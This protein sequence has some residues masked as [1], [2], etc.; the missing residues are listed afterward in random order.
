[1][2]RNTKLNLTLQV[3]QSQ[4]NLVG[5]MGNSVDRPGCCDLGNGLGAEGQPLRSEPEDQDADLLLM[6]LGARSQPRPLPLSS[7]ILPN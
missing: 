2:E 1:M 3:H 6:R 7:C 4:E 5:P